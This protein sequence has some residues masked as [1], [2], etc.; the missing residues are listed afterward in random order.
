MSQPM[1]SEARPACKQ[2]HLCA[3][4]S[5]D[6]MDLPGAIAGETPATP[7]SYVDPNKDAEFSVRSSEYLVR[8][9]ISAPMPPVETR[10]KNY[11]NADFGGRDVLRLLSQHRLLCECKSDMVHHL[12]EMSTPCSSIESPA[13][14]KRPYDPAFPRLIIGKFSSTQ[15]QFGA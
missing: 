15:C 7:R 2:G 11:K 4:G 13:L 8:L 6:P 14:P 9:R 1:T 5:L 3:Y 10:Y 12:F